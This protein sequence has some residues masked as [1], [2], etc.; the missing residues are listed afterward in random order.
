MII[1][2]YQNELNKIKKLSR[3]FARHYPAIAP[4]LREQGTDPDVERLLEG[5][6]FLTSQIQMVMDEQLPEMVDDLTQLFFPQ[7]AKP[8]PSTSVIQFIPKENLGE[9]LM[10]E[11]GTELASIPV[12]GVK[13]LFRTTIPLKVEP[14]I[15]KSI[16][17]QDSMSGIGQIRI[18]CHLCGITLKNWQASS[19]RFFI[20]QSWPDA[21]NTFYLL[22]KFVSKITI[23]AANEEKLVLSTE[24]LQACALEEESLYPASLSTHHP[25]S[26]LY[27]YINQPYKFLF[28]KLTGLDK[29]KKISE[30]LDFKITIELNEVPTWFK[31]LEDHHL[32]LHAVPIINLFDHYAEPI[33][34]DHKQPDYRVLPSNDFDQNYAVY[35]IKKVSGYRQQEKKRI[36]YDP[37]L[38]FN[39][40]LALNHKYTYHQRPA[41]SR[42]GRD[43]YIRFY[44]DF[45]NEMPVDET[46]SI[47]LTCTNGTLTKILSAGDITQPTDSSPENLTF[48]NL[49]PPSAFL[50]PV[51][52]QSLLW[53]FQSLL[54]LNLL[55]LLDKNNLQHV[56]KLYIYE[57]GEN[58][59]INMSRVKGIENIVVNKTRRLY[60]GEMITGSHITLICDPDFFRCIGDLYLFGCVLDVFFG[61]NAPIN[62]FT[63]LHL[64]NDNRP[65]RD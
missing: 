9:A 22:Q 41:V 11:Q 52:D 63:L 26:I 20:N 61:L 6:A 39:E 58:Y 10:V 38:N 27:E 21:S 36:D 15:I 4:L 48:T 5:V 17:Y 31:N 3:E 44:Y 40:E 54:A 45:E 24:H 7:Y 16:Q 53:N 57:K 35:E 29:W 43:T 47:N 8:V 64:Q 34:L 18:N 28:L 33:Y 56:F 49:I 14:V 60:L 1:D 32:V 50:F 55:Q 13:C 30:G 23:E 37:L 46:L 12:N 65:I 19:L 51:Y 42:R 62:T 2:Y 59:H 25:H